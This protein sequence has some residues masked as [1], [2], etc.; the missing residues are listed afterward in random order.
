MSRIGTAFSIVLLSVVVVAFAAAA[1]LRIDDFA[2]DI[3]VESSGE[4]LVTERITAHFFT[5]HHGIERFITISEKTPW[6]E[7]IKIDLTVDRVLLDGAPVE[8]TSRTRGSDHSLRIGDPNRTITGIHQYTIEYR[9]RRALLFTQNAV[10]LYWNV[11]GND[12][13]VLI[14]QASALV[15][16]PEPVDLAAVSPIGY[17]GYYGSSAR[18]EIGVPTEAGG[19][20]FETGT[21]YPG[22]GLTITVTVPRDV[23]PIETPSSWQRILWFL[24]SNRYAALPFLTLIGMLVLW[25]KLG[26]DPRKRVIAPV[27]SPPRGMHPGAVGVL[28]DDR[29]DLRDISAMLV[30]LAVKGYLTI[31]EQDDASY[32]FRR[33]RTSG[34]GLSPPEQAVFETLF[35]SPEVEE[36]TLVS[37]EQ[38]FYK[39]LPTIRSRL[40]G[41]LIKAGYYKS[42]PERTK[43][44]YVAIGLLA[45]AL[46]IYL[47]AQSASL[48]LAVATALSGL[49]VLAFSRFMPRKTIKGVRM[50]EEILGLSKY[51]RKAEVERIEFHNAPE[52]GL[53]VF[54]KLLPYAIALNLTAVWTKQFAGL[55]NEPPT[56]YSGSTPSPVFNA[57]AFSHVL[58]TMTRNMQH[59][60]ASAPRTSGKSAWSGRGTFGGGF[61]GG[62]FSG[63]GFGGGGGSGW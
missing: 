56:W 49:I 41:Q 57:L 62:G 1:T 48:Y 31:H 5:E 37:L 40:Y 28:I 36:R 7:T 9:V 63:G 26:R 11:T 46:A 53:D 55:L 27:F 52:K 42:N 23:L 24:D 2:V 51:I 15:H 16:L 4:L 43:R 18:Q 54:E 20:L 34:D 59:T 44:F 60:F 32:V 13:D 58:S 29:I 14:L 50:L 21:L 12:W 38:E 61:S 39:S 3:V 19:L 22:E 25:T 17:S 47:G 33:Q 8:Y 45:I 6:G 35:D 10:R 30:G